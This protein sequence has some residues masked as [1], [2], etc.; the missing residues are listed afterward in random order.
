MVESL[1][2]DVLDEATIADNFIVNNMVQMII[3]A[4]N[5]LTNNV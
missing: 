3:I 5:Y 2:N 1:V 4:L